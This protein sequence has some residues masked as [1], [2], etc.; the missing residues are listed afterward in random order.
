MKKYVH[1]DNYF[2]KKGITKSN[3]T[4]MINYHYN[5][6]IELFKKCENIIEELDKDD[7]SNQIKIIKSLEEIVSGK[8][9]TKAKNIKK[10]L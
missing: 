3:L 7:I 8:D 6:N 2:A 4:E 9:Q 1:Q 5:E 10:N